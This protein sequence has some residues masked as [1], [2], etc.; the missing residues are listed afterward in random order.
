MRIGTHKRGVNTTVRT[1][2]VK[3]ELVVETSA[4][5]IVGG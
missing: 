4:F 3:R 1:E 5:A 2:I